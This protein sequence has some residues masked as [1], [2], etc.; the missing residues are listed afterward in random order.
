MGSSR[1]RTTEREARSQDLEAVLP[2]HKHHLAGRVEAE[3]LIHGPAGIGAM[4]RDDGNAARVR[5]SQTLLDEIVRQAAPAELRIDVDIQQIAAL[6]GPG[7]EWVRRPVNDQQPGRACDA[8][9]LFCDPAQIASLADPLAYP[10][11][12]GAAHGVEDCVV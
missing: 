8:Q 3:L 5:F 7:M 12:K 9:I 1:Y 6:A 4:Q 11:L 2:L 10:R